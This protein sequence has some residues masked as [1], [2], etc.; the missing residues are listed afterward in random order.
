MT[1]SRPG[2]TFTVNLISDGGFPSYTYGSVSGVPLTV[3]RPSA[4]QHCT[5]SP[6]TP[7][8]RLIRSCSPEAGSS[9]MKVKNSFTC[10]TTT[11]SG[12]GLGSPRSQPPGSL[13]TTTSPR[14]GLAPNHGV[15][16]ST[17]TRSPIRMVCSIEPDGM[18]NAC[19]RN[20]LSTSAIS[21]ATMTSSGTSL[22]RPRRRLR[23]TLRASLRR[24]TRLAPSS[25]GGSPLSAPAPAPAD[26]C[27]AS[28]PGGG[29]AW[30][31]R[32]RLPMPARRRG[33][34]RGERGGTA[35]P[36]PVAD[37]PGDPLGAADDLVDRHGSAAGVAEVVA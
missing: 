20:V 5:V 8:T 29:C 34:H 35:Q 3:M 15:N 16:L 2:G 37:R 9:P 24:S 6:P 36:R 27:W 18:T 7:I 17:S 11:G 10:L 1:H 33:G 31:G 19:T 22:A 4:S 14:C 28:C 25:G 32:P 23:R 30:R 21:S 12:L 13:K 26:P